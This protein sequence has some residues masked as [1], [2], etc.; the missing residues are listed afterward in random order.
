MTHI[1]ETELALY[2]GGDLTASESAAVA[3]HL[4]QCAECRNKTEELRH[5][6]EWLRT[7][8]VEPDAEQ[9]YTLRESV[10]SATAPMPRWKFFGFA[11]AVAACLALIILAVPRFKPVR[12]GPSVTTVLPP[13]VSNHGPVAP[14]VLPSRDWQGA[15]RAKAR[16]RKKAVLQLTL[17]AKNNEGAPVIR[18]KTSDPNVVILWVVGNGSEQEKNNE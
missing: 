17:V 16:V 1:P 10:R 12:K 11:A 2:A 4:E 5:A 18:V 13:V 7:V 8:A 14:L 3:Q 15:V 6:A 9:I